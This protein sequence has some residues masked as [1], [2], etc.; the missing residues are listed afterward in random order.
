LAKIAETCWNSQSGRIEWKKR[1]LVRLVGDGKM[2]SRVTTLQ[3]YQPASP[4]ASNGKPHTTP[5][6]HNM[7]NKK[8]AEWTAE[9]E[10][11]LIR[12]L[13]AES[14]AGKKAEN[15]FKKASWEQARNKINQAHRVSYDITQLKSKWSSVY[16]TSL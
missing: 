2:T 16:T 15:G 7:P 6:I 5:I 3:I 9:Q 14:R 4:R 13:L 12:T 1:A 8:R 11:T 10:K